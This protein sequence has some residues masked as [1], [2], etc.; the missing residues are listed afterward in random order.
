MVARELVK[1]LSS[2]GLRPSFAANI[3]VK[4]KFYVRR[5]TRSSEHVKS[6]H[7]GVLNPLRKL[8]TDAGCGQSLQYAYR[9]V[10]VVSN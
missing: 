6:Q 8:G 3:E 2:Q 5:N 4:M 9:S 10:E 7:I 1:A